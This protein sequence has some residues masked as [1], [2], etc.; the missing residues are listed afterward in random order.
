MAEK[1]LETKYPYFYFSTVNRRVN[2]YLMKDEEIYDNVNFWSEKLGSKAVRPGYTLFMDRVDES[3]V[4]G[5]FYEKFPSGARRL[6]RIS[7]TKIYAIDPLVATAWGTAGYTQASGL[8]FVRPSEAMLAAKMH[9]VSQISSTVSD[10]IEYSGTAFT[11]RSDTSST[12][13]VVPYQAASIVQFHR[14]IYAISPYYSPNTYASRISWSSIDYE[15]KGTAPASPWVIDTDDPSAAYYR[16]IDTDYRGN[17]LKAT[18]INDRVN[19]YKEGGI[20]RYNEDTMFTLFGLGAYRGSISTMDETME[21]YFFT[22]EG[23]FKTDGKDV[24]PISES[25]YNVIKQILRNGITV[26]KIHSFALN[27]MYY[28]YMG[29]V[30]YDG[31]TIANACFVYNAK[32]GEM[33]LWSFYHDITCFGY[34]PDVNGEKILLL[35]D[36]N[37]YTYKAGMQYDDDYGQPIAAHLRSK[38][39][40]FSDPNFPKEVPEMW[41]Y[42]SPGSQM[43]ILIDKD[44]LN[45]YKEVGQINQLMNYFKINSDAV[46]RFTALSFKI[47][48]N[49]KGKRP[50]FNGVIFNIR[51]SVEAP[52][53]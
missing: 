29:N 22:N 28:C 53:G 43:Q 11:L 33:Y 39:Y 1:Y 46:G 41:A 40:L 36:V 52:S 24:T 42:G 19:I 18:S 25:W 9:I 12:D 45:Q 49:G 38:Y 32:T 8:D 13:V 17:I 37:G 26:S 44:F 34:Y 35:G 30:T 4:K 50:D 16:P 51:S 48:W 14:R 47:V 15:N 3:P 20:Y 5:I 31:Q 23:F 10:Y 27:F 6:I 7:G 2:P 21:D